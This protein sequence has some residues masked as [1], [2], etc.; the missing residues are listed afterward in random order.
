MWGRAGEEKAM[1]DARQVM[2]RITA[3]VT[4]GDLEAVAACYAPDAVADTPDAGRLV[5]R[6]AIVGYLGE[7]VRAFSGMGYE[8]IHEM[9]SGD[10]AVDE[11]YLLGT[12]TGPLATPD[13]EI[14]PTGRSMR[15]RECDVLTVQDGLATSHRFYYDLLDFTAQLGLAP[16]AATLP[17]QPSAESRSTA[18]SSG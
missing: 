16:Q 8:P 9:E 2:D 13:G 7:F 4:A 14:A 18:S 3:A 1:G 12:H 17:Q 5:G 15:I 6:D 10:T 11:G